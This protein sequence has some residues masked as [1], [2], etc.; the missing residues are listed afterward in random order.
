[1]RE[2]PAGVESRYGMGWTID[3]ARLSH[4]GILWTYQA[5][6]L[7]MPESGYGIVILFGSGLNA[8]VN[9]GTFA[10][11]IADILSGE[12]PPK[13]AISVGMIEAGIALLTLLTVLLWVRGFFFH[14]KRWEHKARQRRVWLTSLRM[15]ATLIPL[16]IFISLPQILTFVGGGRVVKWEQI[17]L[18]MPS[19]V[20]WLALLSAFGAIGFVRKALCM[21]S[22]LREHQKAQ[23]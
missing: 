20:I 18:L 15:L 17:F 10:S 8:L 1:M 19:V 23:A 5:D 4:N 11:G 9:Y 12:E 7:L 16:A 14:W 6:Q 2:V 13:S 3:G 22:I 21:V